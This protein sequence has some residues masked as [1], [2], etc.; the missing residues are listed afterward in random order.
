MDPGIDDA[1]ALYTALGR[2]PIAGLSAVAGNVEIEKTFVN[3]RQLLR[4]AG[5]SDVPV[6]RGSAAPLH[7]PLH[8]A[9]HVHGASGLDGYQFP[10]PLDDA[11]TEP[12]WA[13]WARIWQE[14]T[15][16]V[17][18]IATGP[19]TNIAKLLWCLDDAPSRL[20]GITVMGGAIHA[21]NVTPTAE[22]N[23]YADPEAADQVMGA[24]VPVTMVGLDVTHKA[25]L[26]WEDLPRF[27][28][29][30]EPGRLLYAVLHWYGEHAER[31]PDGLAIHD[32][33]AVAAYA[34]PEL[35]VWQEL[36][37]TV[38]QDAAWRGTVARL[39]ESARRPRVKAAVDVDV[40]GVL[41]WLWGS[42]Q[43]MAENSPAF[44]QS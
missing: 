17:H 24:N 10:A 43:A 34:N 32:A 9:P 41:N 26:P 20:T 12:P 21:G 4:L 16:P 13:A 33:I 3:A 44:R 18:L 6:W 1:L 14:E 5:R 40:P 2:L 38:L 22:F 35:F 8:T 37:L 7:Y 11:P 19:L 15:T 36:P 42:L 28:D 39:P 29:F 27:L 23:F 25:R 31:H 30:A